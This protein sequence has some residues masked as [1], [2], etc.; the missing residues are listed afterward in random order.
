VESVA[1]VEAVRDAC[2]RARAAGRRVGLVPTM[3][4]LHA[5]H[6]SLVRLARQ[7]AD[8]VVV[9]VFVNPTQFGPGEDLDAYPRTLDEDRRRAQ[10]AGADLVFAPAVKE[11]YP[12]GF[13]TRVHVDG[14]SDPLCGASRPG[15][16][17]GVALVV[18]KLLNI[19]RP[20]VSVFG[21]KD[22][23][24]AL[25]IR[26]LARDLDLP[27]RIVIGPTVRE[28][29]GVAMSSRNAYLAP[30]ER[31][32]ARS[33]S[34]GLF[35]AAK[36]WA[37][38]ERDGARLV[39]AAREM[40]DAEPLVEPEYA[41]LRRLDDLAPWDGRGPALLAVAARVGRARLIDNVILEDDGAAAD[42]ATAPGAE[43]REE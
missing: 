7:H 10:T 22:A 5:G 27:G 12:E 39:A 41:E 26:R 38:G 14:L 9:S 24:Q 23:Q 16:F 29:D 34:G 8:F 33:L 42:L 4:A 31:R 36:V 40:M 3:G 19:V 1:T 11:M 2:G 43:R 32:A 25:L 30:D 17:D 28:P 18:T 35:A 15:H 37:G 6:E 21:Q 13:A 20:D